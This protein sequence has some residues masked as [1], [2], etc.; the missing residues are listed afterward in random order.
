[1]GYSGIVLCALFAFLKLSVFFFP[2]TRK[3]LMVC[4]QTGNWSFILQDCTIS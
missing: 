2:G 1:M 3:S 4:T